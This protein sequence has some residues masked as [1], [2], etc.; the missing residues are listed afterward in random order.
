MELTTVHEEREARKIAGVPSS[1]PSESSQDAQ[2]WVEP[3]PTL[4]EL[5]EDRPASQGLGIHS[6]QDAKPPRKE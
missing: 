5:P 2:T 4:D 1:K 6:R 3:G